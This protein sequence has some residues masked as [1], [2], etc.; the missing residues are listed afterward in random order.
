MPKTIK[1]RTTK[2][3][4]HEH[5]PQESLYDLRERLKEKQQLL[6]YL[7]SGFIAVLIVVVGYSVYNKISSDK[8]LD[9]ETAAYKTLYADFEA[10]PIAPE[11]RLKKA[12]DLFKKSYD[13]KKRPH[14]LFMIA[15]CYFDM[16]NYDEAIKK[17]QD[18]IDRKNDPLITPMARY[19]MAMAYLKKDDKPKA[20]S[21]FAVIT[22]TKEAVAFQDLALLE[23]ARLLEES[24]KPE[25]AKAKYNELITRFPQS[26]AAEEARKKTGAK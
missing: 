4:G 11:E 18:L 20:F 10:Q 7:L 16:G 5:T 25:E 1:K 19:K 26:A 2:H 12:L 6:V 3:T 8:A 13:A 24:G 17:L 15:S 23:N 22:S 21:I 9:L 14:V